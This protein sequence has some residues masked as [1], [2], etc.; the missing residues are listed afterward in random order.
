MHKKQNR[1]AIEV[2]STHYDRLAELAVAAQGRSPGAQCLAE[3][4]DRARIVA[5]LPAA[6]LGINDVVTFEY[7]GLYYYEVQLVFPKDADF[8]NRR[9]SV[10]T[11][12]GA[13]LL[14]LAEGQTIHW[15]GADGRSH[16]VSVEKVSKATGDGP[17]AAAEKL[18]S[19]E[20]GAWPFSGLDLEA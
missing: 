17:V 11:P 10:L 3:E 19:V 2:A 7:D 14:G 8:K 18:S 12:V 15:Y 13:M 6:R 16:R 5:E 20:S 9:L 4:L 1:P